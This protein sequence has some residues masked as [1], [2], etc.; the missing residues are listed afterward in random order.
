[1][2]V[3]LSPGA[4]L[5]QFEVQRVLA[6]TDSGVDLLVKKSSALQANTGVADAS[7]FSV[8]GSGAPQVSK[9]PAALK[10][11]VAAF[12]GELQ[13]PLKKGP[14]MLGPEQVKLHPMPDDGAGAIVDAINQAKK[15]IDLEVYQLADRNVVDALEAAAKRGVAVRIMVE[16]KALEPTNYSFIAKQLTAAGVKMQPTPPAFDSH[17]NVDHAKFMVVDSREVLFGTGNLVRVGLGGNDQ[18]EANTRDFWVEDT[19]AESLSEASQ[20]FQA[21]WDRKPTT[22]ITFKNLVVTPDDDAPDIDAVIDSVPKGGN[23]RVY[24]QELSDKATIQK[25]LDAK[26]RG[27]NVQVLL[28]AFQLK[29]GM[30][31]S[32]DPAVKTLRAAGIDVK[33]MTASYLHAKAVITDNQAFVGS[34]NF[35]GGGMVRNREVG[36]IF[37]QPA[38]L[39]QLTSTFTS[40]W[41]NPGPQP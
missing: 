24:N 26:Q 40:D 23:L 25:L 17:Q 7:T 34:Q 2:H 20:L 37:K 12:E 35:T 21:D 9:D 8:P 33:Y 31:P 30:P 18:D 36:E 4:K 10:S 27:A 3:V 13:V 19:Q 38:L 16:P 29:P 6:L 15:S 32:N 14:G 41:A 28:G 1:V 5:D 22:G 39:K 11:S